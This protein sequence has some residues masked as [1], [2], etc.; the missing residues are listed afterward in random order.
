MTD[1]RPIDCALYGSYEVAIFKHKRARL[2]WREADGRIRIDVLKPVDLNTRNHEE[3]L[4]AEA[5]DGRRLEMR[6][7]RIIKAEFL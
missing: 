6:L 1:Y 2:S 3:F 4:I 7:D 5:S